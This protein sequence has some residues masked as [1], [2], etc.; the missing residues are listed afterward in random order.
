M[1]ALPIWFLDL[2]HLMHR[3][4]LIGI[5]GQFAECVLLLAWTA[6]SS[7]LPIKLIP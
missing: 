2:D 7:S 5:L 6:L 3:V 1:D 4:S